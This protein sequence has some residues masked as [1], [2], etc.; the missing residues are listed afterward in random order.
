[1]ATDR[2]AWILAY[3]P[4]ARQYC[5]RGRDRDL[6]AVVCI[7]LLGQS[8]V[9]VLVIVVFSQA[10]LMICHLP[11]PLCIAARFQV[12]REPSQASP[13]PSLIIGNHEVLLLVHALE[14]GLICRARRYLALAVACRLHVS[15]IGL[16]E[17]CCGCRVP[18]LHCLTDYPARS[19]SSAALET[20][21]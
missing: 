11:C 18:G 14:V 8:S 16:L 7:P 21:L 13:L 19:L 9:T 6:L 3:I 10:S 2:F 5:Q 4:H 15:P 12:T 1:M 20:A 17:E